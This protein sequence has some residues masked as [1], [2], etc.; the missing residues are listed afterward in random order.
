MP[1][2]ERATH[3]LMART[4]ESM[5]DK[6]EYAFPG[7]ALPL[8]SVILGCSLYVEG[9]NGQEGLHERNKHVPPLHI[10]F[11]VVNRPRSNHFFA[12]AEVNFSESCRSSS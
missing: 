10:G 4:I 5:V 12:V 8:T 3:V 7:R 6:I 11:Q 9:R 1:Q 2:I